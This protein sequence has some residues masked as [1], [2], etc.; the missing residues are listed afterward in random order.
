MTRACANRLRALRTCPI[1]PSPE[2]MTNSVALHHIGQ[3]ERVGHPHDR[4]R[5]NDNQIEDF[6]GHGQ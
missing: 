4:R 1:R 5:V 3:H 6:A 2:A